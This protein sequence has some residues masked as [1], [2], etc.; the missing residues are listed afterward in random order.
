M[1]YT[2]TLCI[3]DLMSED[4]NNRL[5]MSDSLRGMVPEL[6][7]EQFKAF[8]DAFVIVALVMNDGTAARETTGNLVGLSLESSDVVKVDVRVSVSEAYGV[9]KR[10]LSSGLT[11]E[12]LQL[13]LGDEG[14]RIDGPRRAS[15]AKMYDFDHHNKMCVLALDLVRV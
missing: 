15:V 12:V 7:E 10:H 3:V 9:V 1:N 14:V 8:Q 13:L 2:G 5:L 11:C 6:E 4:P